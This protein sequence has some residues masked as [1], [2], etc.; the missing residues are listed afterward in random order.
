MECPLAEL[1]LLKSTNLRGVYEFQVGPK[2]G[3][4]DSIFVFAL[5]EYWPE[6]AETLSL[7]SVTYEPGSPGRVFKLD[8]RS[9]VERLSRP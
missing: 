4:P 6:N 2:P 9:V 1:E 8:E 3:L 7:E 5:A